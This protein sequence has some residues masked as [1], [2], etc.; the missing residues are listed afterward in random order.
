[1][2]D[3]VR[4]IEPCGL[5]VATT[6][7]G[8]GGSSLGYRMAGYRVLWANEF[9]PHAA[10]VYQANAMPATIVNR[11]DIRTLTPEAVL[12]EIGIEAGE[13]DVLDG[14]PPCQSFSTAG[15]LSSGWGRSGQHADGTNQRSDDLFF[16][17]AR[18]LDGI[19]PR[20][21]VAE[22]VSGLV[23]GVAKGYFKLILA[24]LKACGY[25]VEARVLDAAWLGVPQRRQRVIFVGVREDLR[26]DPV[27]PPPLP[28]RYALKDA[29]P[30]VR[31]VDTNGQF[32]IERLGPEDACP[33][34]TTQN[35]YH[36]KVSADRLLPPQLVRPRARLADPDDAA[37]TITTE[38][39]DLLTFPG[40]LPLPAPSVLRRLRE[41]HSRA[42][43]LVD[44]DG[45][46]PTIVGS[47]AGNYILT[48]A[49]GVLPPPGKETGISDR[50]R[51]KWE[52]LSEGEQHE[53][54]FNLIRCGW[55]VPAPTM[56]VIW[57]HN[58]GINQPLHP[59]E[60]RRFSIPELKRICGF[61]DDFVLEGSFGDCWARLGNS[62]PPP[63]MR[64][65]AET[66]R[67]RMLLPC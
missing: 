47:S 53:T 55:D 39:R 23:K 45:Q 7:A 15:K 59:S 54:Y 31:G 32:R 34:I 19:R 41:G 62:V 38:S 40:K 67:D 5:T 52:T 30:W 48:T 61:P 12:S 35:V 11:T 36:L 2:M 3:E 42:P 10:D 46:A 33:A 28:Y 29:I 24:R 43:E 8:C 17:Y 4:A 13:L 64:A 14:S 60:P 22:N 27:H 25:R 51:G 21:F 6:F 66:L 65:V 58:P 49:P 1:M 57:G 44:P 26:K 20:A 16:E 9:L 63:M 37:P 50:L 18:L 56:A